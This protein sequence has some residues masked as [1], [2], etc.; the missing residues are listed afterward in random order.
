MMAFFDWVI[1]ILMAIG[2]GLVAIA[3]QWLKKKL[4]NW[5]IL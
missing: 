5:K 3:Y 4:E 2:F 1:I